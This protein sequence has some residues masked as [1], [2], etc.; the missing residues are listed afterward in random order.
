MK[1]TSPGTPVSYAARVA[2]LPEDRANARRDV[3]AEERRRMEGYRRMGDT[4]RFGRM[5]VAREEDVNLPFPQLIKVEKAEK[6]IEGEEKGKTEEKGRVVYDVK[7]A[8]RM[9][10]VGFF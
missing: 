5:N 4:A 9:V 3:F 1:N 2:P 7:D 8:I 6:K 10:K